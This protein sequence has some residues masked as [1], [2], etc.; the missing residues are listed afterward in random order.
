M[1]IAKFGFVR[2]TIVLQCQAN[3]IIPHSLKRQIS[4]FLNEF[5]EGRNVYKEWKSKPGFTAVA[6]LSAIRQ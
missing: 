1:F 2:I 4:L 6:P 5:I 3:L